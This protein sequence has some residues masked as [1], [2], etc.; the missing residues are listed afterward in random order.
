[1]GGCKYNAKLRT[2]RHNNT[3]KLLHDLLE[4]HNCGK[5]PVL[6]MDLGN[7]PV[8]DFKAQ[9]YMET[10][11]TQEDHKLQ[12]IEATQEGL[13]N[14]KASINHPTIIPNTILPK[15]KR[16]KHYKPGII[17]AIGYK[18]NSQDDLVEN[19]TYK[20]RRC[21]QLIECKYST[22]INISDIIDNIY[23]IYAPLKQAILQ[24]NNGL[25]QV[26]VIT[27]VIHRTCNFH[28][29][30]M[31]EIAQLVSFKENPP[32]TLTYKSLPPQAQT[33]ATSLHIHAQEWLTLM[34]KISRSS[35]THRHT[36]KKTPHTT[37]DK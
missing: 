25:L 26:E 29:R 9:M 32:N 13:Q 4:T 22:Y 33:F 8:R 14:G 30:T 6:N 15:H 36:Q 1:L 31:V 10:T 28:T 23:A 21:V 20:G 34:S 24:Y 5:W 17:R 18:T 3:F 2:Y 7:K 19:T 12:S 11:T 16:P 37:H 35:L 27:I